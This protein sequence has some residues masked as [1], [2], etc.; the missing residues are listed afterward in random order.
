MHL[1]LYPTPTRTSAQLWSRLCAAAALGLVA[2]MGA[3]AEAQAQTLGPDLVLNGGFETGTPNGANQDREPHAQQIFAGDS[4]SLAGWTATGQQIAWLGNGNR[5]QLSTP[6]GSNFLDLTG[7]EP[8]GFIA[9]GISQVLNTQIGQRYQ[10]GFD[11]GNTSSGSVGGR[12][13]VQARFGGQSVD[14]VSQLPNGVPSNWQ[15]FSFEFVADS[16][17][18]TLAFQGSQGQSYIGLDNVTVQAINPVPEPRSSALILAGLV[19]VGG[20]MRWRGRGRD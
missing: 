9:S 14:A 12:I 10:L 8:G 3:Q 13:A 4:Q 15:H 5:Y 18:S 1:K 19:V 11:L 17:Q 7:W 16:A 2:S 6:F 20:F